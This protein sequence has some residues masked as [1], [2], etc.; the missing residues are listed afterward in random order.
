MRKPIYQMNYEEFKCYC[1]DR[2]GIMISMSYVVDPITR[3]VTDHRRSVVS[4]QIPTINEDGI[5]FMDYK[6]KEFSRLRE[7]EEYVSKSRKRDKEFF[8]KLEEEMA[9]IKG[10]S[11]DG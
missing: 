1:M 3:I 10:G 7:A 8:K 11:K 6:R 9:R 5:C 2:W 4:V